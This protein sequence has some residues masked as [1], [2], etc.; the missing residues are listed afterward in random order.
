MTEPRLLTD[1]EITSASGACY[2]PGP[3]DPYGPFD[4]LGPIF[5]PFPPT[6]PEPIYN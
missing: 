1:D 5:W 3:Y 6:F 2:Y 4:P